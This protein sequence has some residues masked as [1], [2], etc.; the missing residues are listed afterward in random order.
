MIQPTFR[1]ANFRYCDLSVV[2]ENAVLR[3]Y[4]S[5]M[6]NALRSS[7]V[8]RAA[9]GVFFLIAALID[10]STLSESQSATGTKRP[11]MVALS[12]FLPEKHLVA[13]QTPF[14]FLTVK[15]LSETAISFPQDRV[16]VEGERGEAATTLRQRQLT[17]RRR[18]GEP[19]LLGGGFEPNVEP[20]GK[21]T[22]KYDL[23]QL[24]DV[25]IPGKYSVYIEVFDQASGSMGHW[26][27]SPIATFEVKAEAW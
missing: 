8:K 13:G 25:S 4:D 7:T 3:E 2:S 16:Y 23:S 21:F 24:Y 12:I 5:T 9:F 17:Q 22:R 10:A 11:Q 1:A 18:P 14:V 20:R 26:V 6:M 19:S 27:R 15:N